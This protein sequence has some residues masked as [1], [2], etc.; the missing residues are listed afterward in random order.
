M[1]ILG[2]TLWSHVYPENTSRISQGHI[3]Y[4]IISVE[5]EQKIS[6]NKIRLQHPITID[7]TNEWHAQQHAWLLQEIRKA[8]ANG[9]HVVIITHHAPIRQTICSKE[10]AESGLADAY[11]N[12]HEADC[13]ALVCLW[14][15]GH[16]HQPSYVIVNSTRVISNQLGYLGENCGFRPNMKITLYDDGSVIVADASTFDY[17]F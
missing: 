8:R 7:D 2:T 1:R 11:F 12:D 10:Y 16:T 6:G 13:V 5:E 17:S 4:R 3:D 14:M 9:E 15:H